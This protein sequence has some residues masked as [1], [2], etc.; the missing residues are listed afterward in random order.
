MS[1][2]TQFIHWAH[3]DKKILL[4]G[5]TFAYIKNIHSAN[6]EVHTG[7]NSLNQSMFK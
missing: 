4:L 7:V 5:K 1:K 2:L 3:L 6:Y